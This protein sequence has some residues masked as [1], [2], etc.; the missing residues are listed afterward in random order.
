MCINNN[1]PLNSA[2]SARNL[3]LPELS[4]THKI[5]IVECKSYEF[6]MPEGVYQEFGS[7]KEKV[8]VGY[9]KHYYIL[10]NIFS[11]EK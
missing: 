1:G 6:C 11:I 4:V 7:D 5:Q 9:V 10:S 2:S 3:K 8:V